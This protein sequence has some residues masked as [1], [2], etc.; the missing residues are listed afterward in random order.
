[1][2]LW[3][4][5]LQHQIRKYGD[6]DSLIAKL[7][8]LGVND[9]CIKYH[10]GSSSIGGGINFKMDFLSYVGKFKKSGFRVGTWGYNC[11]N[12]IH[13]EANLIIEALN[14]S[15]YY[16][17]DLEVDAAGKKAQAEKVCQIVRN[18][19]PNGIIG[20][21]SFPIISL[22][23]DIPYSI[24]NKYCDFASPQCYWGEM[25]WSLDRC[26]DKMILDYKTYGLDKPIYPSI[27]TYTINY[28]DFISYLTYKFKK[29]GLWSLDQMDNTCQDFINNRRSELNNSEGSTV[30]TNGGNKKIKNIVVYGEG[31]DKRAAEYLADYLKCPICNRDNLGNDVIE[32]TEK[33]YMV[34]GTWKPTD[35]T[36][37]I[38][39][40]DRFET[41]KDVLKQLEKL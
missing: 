14:N 38:S 18:T 13:E 31:A 2:F 10:E 24:F 27:Q 32:S 28:N 23:Q 5:Q 40:A 7:K 4:W 16:V 25:Q 11:F 6:V 39:G 22:H 8:A 9:V 1:M 26:I 15:D 34:G 12:N 37:L 36:M 30:V 21:S 33:I 19:H 17:F 29:T 41:I 3:I 35:K 20:Y